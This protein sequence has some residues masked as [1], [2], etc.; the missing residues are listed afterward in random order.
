MQLLTCSI[1][2][3][4]T[5]LSRPKP[6][7][8]HQPRFVDAQL[9]YGVIYANRALN[10]IPVL[11][12]LVGNGVPEVHRSACGALRNLSYGKSNDEN[13]VGTLPGE[14]LTLSESLGW[15]C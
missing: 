11:V 14:V 6:G 5:T 12:A 13:K 15:Y 8:H 10:G 4:W 9:I 7:E 3:T 1:C 2:A